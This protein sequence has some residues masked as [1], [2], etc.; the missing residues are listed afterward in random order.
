MS[1]VAAVQEPGAHC[2]FLDFASLCLKARASLTI[3]LFLICTIVG[4]AFLCLSILPY[5]VWHFYVSFCPPQ[6]LKRRYN[7]T[8][9]LV[10]GAS[11]GKLS[12]TVFSV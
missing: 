2:C 6:N 12:R 7:A 11:S 8:W 1:I 4:A 9:A 3:M 5:L 10:T